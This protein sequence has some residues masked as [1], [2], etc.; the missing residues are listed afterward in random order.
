MT[1]ENQLKPTPLILMAQ[2]MPLRV[3]ARSMEDT[4]P[5]CPTQRE[6]AFLG[7]GH[8]PRPTSKKNS[9]LSLPGCKCFTMLVVG[10]MSRWVL[11][12]DEM[13]RCQQIVSTCFGEEGGRLEWFIIHDKRKRQSSGWKPL[14]PGLKTC[15]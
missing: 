3:F 4:Q 14:P 6:L 7:L 5:S 13:R 11:H 10:V 9:R 15:F 1:K 12:C 2:P 8:I